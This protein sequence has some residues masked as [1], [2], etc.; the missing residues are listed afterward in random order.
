MLSSVTK[1]KLAREGT[2]ISKRKPK[3]DLPYT[4]MLL[5]LM[6]KTSLLQQHE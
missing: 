6:V 2:R 1:E 4:K 5:D 3:E